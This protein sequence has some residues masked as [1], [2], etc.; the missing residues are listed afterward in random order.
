VAVNVSLSGLLGGVD[1][2]VLPFKPAIYVILCG[3]LLATVYTLIAGLFKIKVTLQDA[4]FVILSLCLPWLPI[5]ILIEAVKYLPSF[6]LIS[7]IYTVG[8]LIVIGKA[9]VNFVRGITEL[10][11]CSSVRAWLS[12]VAPI[13]SISIIVFIMYG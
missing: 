5:L 13:L 12:V 9:L 11:G 7:L 8:A 4:F 2:L 1:D 10:A 6:P 3:A